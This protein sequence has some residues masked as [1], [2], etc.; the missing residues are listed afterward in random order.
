MTSRAW[1]NAGLLVV[2]LV[3]AGVAYFQPGK[4]PPPPK[5]ALT[6]AKPGKVDHIS[7]RGGKKSPDVELARQGDH[8][9]LTKPKKLAADSRTVH[10]YLDLLRAKSQGKLDVADKDLGKYGLDDPDLVVELGGHKIALGDRHPIKRQRYVRV[11]GE[12]HLVKLS[13]VRALNKDWTK[14]ASRRLLPEGARITRLDL[15]KVT[16]ER[17]DDGAWKVS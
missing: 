6:D 3:L 5:P 13:A 9:R 4:Q 16:L 15:P 12:V 17:S 1:L 14:I 10:A 2:V 11:D 7:I 8:W